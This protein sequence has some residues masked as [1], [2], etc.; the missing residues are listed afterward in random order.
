MSSV[1]S[2]KYSVYD[3]LAIE[4]IFTEISVIMRQVAKKTPKLDELPITSNNK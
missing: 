1:W 2:E 4:H 3:V